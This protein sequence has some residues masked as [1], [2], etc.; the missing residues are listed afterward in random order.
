MKSLK[1][2]EYWEKLEENKVKCGLCPHYC[3]ISDGKTG[4]CGA[5]TNQNGTLFASSY[6]C[7]TSIA[8]DPI[9]KKP[10]YRFHS[11]K[12]IVSIGSYGCNFHCQFCQNHRISMEY[13]DLKTEYYT[14]ELLTEVALLAVADKNIGIAYT[15]NEPLIGYEFVKDTSILIRKEGLMNVLVTNGYINK[16]PLDNLLPYI[17]AVNVDIKGDE[18]RTYK[19]VGGTLDTVKQFIATANKFCHVEVTTLV[20][21]NANETDIEEIAQWLSKI[22]P[23]ITYHLSRFFP[24]YKYNDRIPTPP[25]TMYR[26][27]DIAKKYLR[28]VFIGNM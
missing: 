6:G 7:V 17:D 8:L 18:E 15:Y 1:I 12:N 22:D 26:V 13:T 2:A 19:K 10:L 21:P 27:S 23:E 11:G 24:R 20:I 14:P 3:I 16:E 5:R 4:R 28:N 25:E 9:E